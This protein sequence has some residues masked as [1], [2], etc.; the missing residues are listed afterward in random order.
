MQQQ[1]P[2]YYTPQEIAEEIDSSAQFVINEITGR[3]GERKSTL[4]AYKVNRYWFI[5]E[6]DAI[7]F[8]QRY[9]GN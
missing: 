5:P 8:V 2:G 1:L 4:K 6:K 9:R 7:A 3:R